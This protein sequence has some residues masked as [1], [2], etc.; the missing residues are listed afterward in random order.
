M[1]DN[2]L[3]DKIE[4]LYLENRYNDII[5]I[6]NTHKE[7]DF[8]NPL[9]KDFDELAEIFAVAYIELNMFNKAI[10]VIDLYIKNMNRKMID[11]LEYQDDLTTFLKFKIEVN[12]K[13]NALIKEFKSILE[14]IKLGGKDNDILSLKP[15]VENELFARYTKI[16]G[17]IMYGSIGLILLCTLNIHFW[18]KSILLILSFIVIYWYLINFIFKKMAKKIYKRL[19][20]FIYG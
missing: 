3:Y 18:G 17:V 16:N 12:Q 6:E 11:D 14:Y 4:E 15:D 7:I 8:F 5:E 10:T 2:D 20:N 9:H 1:S 19:L 13:Q